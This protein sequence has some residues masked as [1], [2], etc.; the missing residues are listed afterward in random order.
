LLVSKI[1]LY[2][3]TASFYENLLTIKSDITGKD[4]QNILIISAETILKESFP[5]K[6]SSYKQLIYSFY[7]SSKQSLMLFGYFREQKLNLIYGDLN[8]TQ[9]VVI[10]KDDLLVLIKI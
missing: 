1:A 8:K 7:K 4:D 5:L 10:D 9:E 6:F 2:K 3:E